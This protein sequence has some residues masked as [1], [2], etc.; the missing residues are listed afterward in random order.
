MAEPNKRRTID[1]HYNQPSGAQNIVVARIMSI[2]WQDT[3]VLTEQ[4]SA[5]K[6]VNQDTKLETAEANLSALYVEPAY[7]KQEAENAGAV[8]AI[9][10]QKIR[11]QYVDSGRDAHNILIAAACEMQADILL[12][13]ELNRNIVNNSDQPTDNNQN[14]ANQ[15][16]SKDL[17]I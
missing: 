9:V 12:I 13:A 3:R 16:R 8:G 14:D 5:R 7:T 1:N 10:A 15:L 17:D 4:T 11:Q 6:S 2:N